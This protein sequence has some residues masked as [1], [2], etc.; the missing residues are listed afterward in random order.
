VSIRGIAP[1][2][3]PPPGLPGLDPGWSRLVEAED[4]DGRRRTW[5]VLDSGSPDRPEARTVGTLLCVHGNP[6][7]G[8]LWRRLLAAGSVGRR[9]WRVVAPDQL[10][11]GFSERTGT[12]RRLD[13]RVDDLSALT[14]AMDMPGPVVV[15][16]HDWGGPIALGWALAHRQQ[17]AGIVLTNTAV[18]QPQT[19]GAPALIRLARTPALLAS[20]T[21]RTQAFLRGTLALSPH[22]PAEVREAYLAP[23]HGAERRLAIGDFVEDI[24]L[25]PTHP[26]WQTLAAIRAGLPGLVDVG[27]LLLW[28]PGDPV[29]GD[30]Y[31]DDLQL[32]LPQAS[33][34][35][36]EGAR[37]LVAEDADVAG[38]V[39]TWLE[40]TLSHGPTPSSHGVHRA[41]HVDRVDRGDRRPLWAALDERAGD[42]STAVAEMGAGEHGHARTVAW[43]ALHDRVRDLA[44]GLAA[45]G[46]RPGERVALLIPPGVDLT[47]AVYACWRIGAVIVLADAGL[48]VRGLHRALR[49]ARP[50]HVIGIAKALAVARALG[51]PGRR[52]AAAQLSSP[53]SRM[54]AAL[55]TALGV[56]ATLDDLS[57]RGAG[58][59]LPEPPSGDD[60]AA[61]LFTSGATGPAKGVVYRHRQLE[62][63]RDVLRTTYGIGPDDRF[64]AAFAPFALYGPA[65]GITSAVPDCDVTAPRTLTAAAL[66]NATAAIGATLVFGSPAALANAVATADGLDA[67]QRAALGGVRL[68]LSAGAPI[69]AALLRRAA[70]LLPAAE[71]HTPYGMTEALPVTDIT[72]SGIEAAGMEVA[73]G[74]EGVCVG[75]PVLGVEVTVRPLGRDG[76]PADDP[77]DVADVAAVTGEI[78]VRAAHVKDRYDRLWLT[79]HT[80][81]DAA[82]WHR[83][84]DVGHLDHAGR[85]WVEGRLVHVV[86]TADGCV[87]PVGPEQRVE[88]LPAV[89]RAAVVGVGPV[90]TQQVVVVVEPMDP[91]RRLAIAPLAL[92]DAVREEAGV[93]VAAV[94]VAP[95]LPVDIR[96]NAKV[97]RGEVARRAAALLAGSRG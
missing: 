43:S 1:A 61:V 18:H 77:A 46:V 36:F 64:V 42:P 35:R 58:A 12:R 63:Q 56:E 78:C 82:G 31:L 73:G 28:G 72:L 62:A 84:G 65:L 45:T 86:V 59:P 37:H 79:Q 81:M 93:E 5:H 66:A 40:A 2:Q 20:A 19:S 15:V 53:I 3:L 11:M 6:T 74:G 14:A 50:R 51:W 32:R 13:R 27:A 7:W 33:V 25:T 39:V 52:I 8:Y 90:G 68:L 48:G 10:D 16:A 94:L 80:S 96:H 60:D 85:L 29:F 88:C 22:L 92:A 30:R 55:R 89:A 4:A 41:D 17:L 91:P 24:P 95:S 76:K 69:P 54:G 47:V 21:V 70:G 38:T 9:A 75:R 26:S 49:G 71:A 97:D 83:T 87:T 44:A 67:R 57:A 34:H 23:Y